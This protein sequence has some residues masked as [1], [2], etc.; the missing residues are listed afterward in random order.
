MDGFAPETNKTKQRIEWTEDGD[1][2]TRNADGPFTAKQTGTCTV[3]AK[4][5]GGISYTWNVSVCTQSEWKAYCM[6]LVKTHPSDC[7]KTWILAIAML[8]S[9]P[10]PLLTLLLPLV[11]PLAALTAPAAYAVLLLRTRFSL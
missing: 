8:F 2:L 5:Y 7:M 10:F 6:H 1:I 3:F 11:V 9:L 4:L